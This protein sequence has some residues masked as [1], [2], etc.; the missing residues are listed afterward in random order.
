MRFSTL[1]KMRC[2]TLMYV[3]S[4]CASFMH[5]WWRNHLTRAEQWPTFKMNVMTEELLH[6][7]GASVALCS[8]MEPGSPMTVVSPLAARSRRNSSSSNDS[9]GAAHA[10]ASAAAPLA[11]TSQDPSRGE[12]LIGISPD[13][14]GYSRHIV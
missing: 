12:F 10:F 1:C 11:M 14:H 13:C 3:A 7:S 6:Q 5:H 9:S 4:R 2:R 8:P